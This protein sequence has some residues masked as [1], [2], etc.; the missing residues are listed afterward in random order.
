M[1]RLLLQLEELDGA[2]AVLNDALRHAP[3]Q[4]EFLVLRGGI[5]GQ[6]PRC[7]RRPTPTCAA[8]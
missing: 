7:T 1:V 5:Y 8:C 2:L 6:P 3:D 4:T